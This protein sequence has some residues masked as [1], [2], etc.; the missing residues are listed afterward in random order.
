MRRIREDLKEFFID[1]YKSPIE[2]KLLFLYAIL[3]TIRHYEE[4]TAQVLKMKM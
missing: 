2:I 3:D 4:V 1:L